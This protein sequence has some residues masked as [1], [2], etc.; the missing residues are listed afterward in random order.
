M[1]GPGLGEAPEPLDAALGTARVVAP[2]LRDD[3]VG[4]AVVALEEAA[5]LAVGR[6]RVG[7]DIDSGDGGC[8]VGTR[9]CDERSRS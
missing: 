4:R 6:G 7:I 8:Y 2:A 9:R 1:A 3:L 5:E